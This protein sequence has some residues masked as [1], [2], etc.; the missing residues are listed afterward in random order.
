MLLPREHVRVNIGKRFLNLFARVAAR[1]GVST[2][3]VD[4][5]SDLVTICTS[6][7]GIQRGVFG[8]KSGMEMQIF[9]SF[10]RA[11]PG[12]TVTF[13]AKPIES[14]NIDFSPVTHRVLNIK[15]LNGD[16]QF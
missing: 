11:I 13:I 9:D 6:N 10:A 14:G 16:E 8:I 12:L 15:F 3:D 1:S 4:S 7:R 5:I 2:S